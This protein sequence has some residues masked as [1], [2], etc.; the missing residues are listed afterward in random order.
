MLVHGE[1][2]QQCKGSDIWN[3]ASIQYLPEV[4]QLGGAWFKCCDL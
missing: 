1:L 3:F 4:D 2:W